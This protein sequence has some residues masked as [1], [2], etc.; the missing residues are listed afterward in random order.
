MVI[1][2][3]KEIRNMKESDVERK[4]RDLRSELMRLDAQRATKSAPANPG[5]IREIRKT[6]AR[7]LTVVGEMK[8][9][10]VEKKGKKEKDKG[11]K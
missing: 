6:I 8:K 10:E 2:R 4:L 11:K 9:E 7:V 1:L 5:R 3:S